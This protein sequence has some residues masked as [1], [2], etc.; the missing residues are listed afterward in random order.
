MIAH[1]LR[2]LGIGYTDHD[3]TPGTARVLVDTTPRDPLTVTAVPVTALGPLL[4]RIAILPRS[5][6]V[7]RGAPALL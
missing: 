3:P 1:G 7:P 5:P 2:G 6:A 4:A